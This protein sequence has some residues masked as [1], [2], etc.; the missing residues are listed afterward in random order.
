[1]RTWKLTFTA[2]LLMSL[3]AMA[4]Q[5]SSSPQPAASQA[6]EAAQPASAQARTANASTQQ[7]VQAAPTTLD[8]VVDRAIEREQGLIKLLGERTP[9][10]ET[11]LQNLQNDPANGPVPVADHYFLGRLD[12]QGDKGPSRRD[13]LDLD[14]SLESKLLGGVKSSVNK[15]YKFEYNPMG[16]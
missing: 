1:M 14:K 15:L 2:C 8:Q 9:L 5:Q 6:T 7:T 10:I 4:Q 16:F 3:S 12:L 11:Y 13:Y